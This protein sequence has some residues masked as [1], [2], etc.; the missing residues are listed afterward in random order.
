MSQDPARPEEDQLTPQERAVS[1]SAICGRACEAPISLEFG[2]GWGQRLGI[3]LW[4]PMPQAVQDLNPSPGQ[5]STT[6]FPLCR[7]GLPFS[8]LP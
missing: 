7:M 3:H 8:L 1:S 6:P 4:A 5:P 2:Y